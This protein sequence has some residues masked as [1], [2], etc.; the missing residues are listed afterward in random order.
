MATKKKRGRPKGDPKIVVYCRIAPTTI[1]ELDLICDS[2]RP[3]P[4]RSQLID[5]ALEDYVQRHRSTKPK[6]EH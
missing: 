2:M 3:K 6:H 4:T 5:V 1:A